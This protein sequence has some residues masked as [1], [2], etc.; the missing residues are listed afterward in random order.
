M[1]KK[2]DELAKG[3]AQSVTRRQA[4]KKFGVGLAAMALACFG[5]ALRA[6]AQPGQLGPLVEL[7]QSD[8][9][10]GCDDGFRGLPGTIPLSAG[11]EPFVAANP[12]HPNNVVAAWIRGNLQDLIASVSF[13]GGRTF[14]AVPVPMTLCTGGAYMGVVDPRVAF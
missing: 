10:R 6:A 9:L 5:L 12:A 11:L 1:N 8:P 4:F 2:F 7:S 13:D 14:Q 3:L